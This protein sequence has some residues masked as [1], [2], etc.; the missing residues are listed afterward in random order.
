[1]RSK[2][3]TFI[4]QVQQFNRQETEETENLTFDFWAFAVDKTFEKMNFGGA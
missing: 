3:S 4:F 1:V 2:N